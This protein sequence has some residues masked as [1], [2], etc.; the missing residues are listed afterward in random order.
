MAKILAECL[1]NVVFLQ[2]TFQFTGSNEDE[3]SFNKDDVFVITKKDDGGWWEGTLDGKIGWF[4][5]NYVKEISS[6][7]EPTPSEIPSLS[8]TE[9][10]SAYYTQV[11]ENIIEAQKKHLNELKNFLDTYLLKVKNSEVLNQQDRDV[12]AS[13]YSD[14]VDFHVDL[15]KDLVEQQEKPIPEQRFGECFLKK[16]K[17]MKEIYLTYC[18]NHPQ[19]AA[20][21]QQHGDELGE[22]MESLGAANPGIMTLTSLLSKPFLYVEKYG[23]QIKELERHVEEDHIDKLDMKK[24]TQVLQ[25]IALSCNEVRKKKEMELQMLTGDIDGWQ[26]DPISSLGNLVHMGQVFL[27]KEDVAR[28]ER[29]FC[30]FP[31]DLIVLSVSAELVGYCFEER[32]LVSD[33]SAKD[34]EDTDTFFNGFQVIVSDNVWQ[35]M[36]SSPREK[37]AWMDAL[38]KVL[39]DKFIPLPAPIVV[40]EVK[41]TGANL[42]RSDSKRSEVKSAPVL[43]HNAENAA[44]LRSYSTGATLNDKQRHTA[45]SAS[46]T[47]ESQ[48]RE[49]LSSVR[50]SV[51]QPVKKE[52]SFTRLR[53]TPPYQQNSNLKTSDTTGSPR[54]MRRI[55]SAKNKM[56]G[57]KGSREDLLADNFGRKGS[58]P[59]TGSLGLTSRQIL[60]EDMMILSVI[61]AYCFSARSRQNMNPG[62]PDSP[63]LP[64]DVPPHFSFKPI[65]PPRQTQSTGKQKSLKKSKKKPMDTNAELDGLKHQV[66]NLHKQTLYLRENLEEERKAR[67]N[68]ERFFKRIVQHISPDVDLNADNLPSKSTPI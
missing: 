18:N 63:F 50:G 13:N 10:A 32:Q 67:E 19:A 23:N 17:E 45:I 62:S 43:D 28:R 2:A 6:E 21:I 22:F 48:R 54:A 52:W 38:K 7:P 33:I 34:V 57:G 53:P 25:I 41:R 11:V 35:V 37:D 44:F 40:P 15:T 58:T 39:N 60:E 61:E 59:T 42:E 56:I 27:E 36:S 4:P 47:P 24:A 51:R 8:S 64:P 49:A 9:E 1:E 14:I 31:N 29:Y 65:T 26:G 12:I 68:F 20:L 30:L 5:N 66:Q 3:L 46:P 16:S 55:V